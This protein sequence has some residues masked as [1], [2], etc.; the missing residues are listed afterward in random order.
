MVGG[1]LLAAAPA[2]AY[3]RYVCKYEQ[4]RREHT[5]TIVG[6]IA[7]GVLGNAVSGHN[8][9]GVGTVV[10]ALGGA[11]IGSKMG[12]DSG[13]KACTRGM[14]YRTETVYSRDSRGR[15]VRTVYRYVRE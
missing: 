14:A 3:T 10:G 5:G 1:A 11:A 2:D 6:A 8:S 7:G 13:K 12:H 9:K 4:K 15:R